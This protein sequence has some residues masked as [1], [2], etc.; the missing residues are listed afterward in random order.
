MRSKISRKVWQPLAYLIVLTSFGLGAWL[1][2]GQW[3]P[4]LYKTAEQEHP[5]DEQSPAIEEAKVLKLSEQ[6]RKNLGLT[7][8]PAKM[9]TYW[10][11]IQIPGVLVDRPG[12][13]D[14][15]I[16]SPIEGVVTQ[17]HAF[18]GDIIQPGEKL[19]TLRLVSE[20]LQQTQSELFKAVRETEIVN[21]EIAR[22]TDLVNSGV[23]PGKRVL[24]LNQ[25]ASRQAALIDANRQDLLS[26]GL[27]AEQIERVKVG[28][29]LTTIEVNAPAISEAKRKFE[30]VGFTETANPA[31]AGFYEIQGLKVE[32]GQQV[33]AGE[34]LAVLA[35]HNSLYVKGYA[36][37]KEASNLARA[38]ENQWTVEVEFTEDAP[39]DWTELNQ[40]FQIRHL[41]NTTD[42]N[43]R[44]FDFFIPLTNQS[45]I[46]EKNGRPF[47]VWRFRPGQR[48]LIHIPVEQIENVLVLPAGAVVREGPEAYVFQQN[49]D[50]FNRISVQ[51]LHQ[52][53]SN[54][55]IANDGKFA[56]GFYLA[57]GSAASLNRVLKAQAASGM[58]ADVHVHA[59]GTTHAAH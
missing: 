4:L 34:L 1:S 3:L 37:K 51:V 14:R 42:A 23:I 22:I 28:N 8:K 55:V 50:L 58:R 19:F 35:N 12:V 57:Q 52:D 11:K 30:S 48:V 24:E 46:Y 25:R 41:A 49:G 33:Q 39:K 31:E 7:A 2:Q 6:A 53:R 32:L 56:P 47:V 20:S 5:A 44:T 16:T 9:Q 38:A 13:T 59:D 27:Q 10:R 54:V 45:R 40:E 15:G 43:S 21:R 26:R 17:V 18:E 36:F 29:F